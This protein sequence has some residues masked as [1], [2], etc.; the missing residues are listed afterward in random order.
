MSHCHA[1]NS[2]K[3][4]IFAWLVKPVTRCPSHID[5]SGLGFSNFDNVLRRVNK[6]ICRKPNELCTLH[7]TLLVIGA[8]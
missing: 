2:R 6:D 7:E 4:V 1:R 3:F 5:T 8:L